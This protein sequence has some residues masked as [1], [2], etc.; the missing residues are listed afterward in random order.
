[1]NFAHMRG[2]GRYGSRAGGADGPPLPKQPRRHSTATRPHIANWNGFL[3][4]AKMQG[5]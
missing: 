4:P 1:M 5:S 2:S 3:G